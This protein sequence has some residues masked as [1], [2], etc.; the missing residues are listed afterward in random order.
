MTHSL[1]A[2]CRQ[3]RTIFRQAIIKRARKQ[4]ALHDGCYLFIRLLVALS[5]LFYCRFPFAI[6]QSAYLV[7]VTHWQQPLP[8]FSRFALPVGAALAL[9]VLFK[10]SR[11][12][13]VRLGIPYVIHRMKQQY[14]MLPWRSTVNQFFG[15]IIALAAGF[16]VGREGPAVHLGAAASTWLGYH[17]DTPKNAVRTLAACGIAAAIAASFNTPLA[18]MVLVMEVVLREYKVHIFIPVMLAAV[19]GYYH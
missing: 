13:R 18:A 10:L 7:N 19:A 9:F 2:A 6:D 4:L 15:G 14:G 12:K 8:R 17:I 3:K 1:Q 5:R 16:S 11:A